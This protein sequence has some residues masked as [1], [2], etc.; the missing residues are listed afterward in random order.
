MDRNKRSEGAVANAKSPVR[1]GHVIT[2]ETSKDAISATAADVVRPA[3]SKQI[4]RKS[5][6]Q[7]MFNTAAVEMFY[8]TP[9]TELNFSIKPKDKIVSSGANPAKEEPGI[10]HSHDEEQ[11]EACKDINRRSSQFPYRSQPCHDFT[12][13]QIMSID[14]SFEMDQRGGVF[15][16]T[17]DTP[18]TLARFTV[19]NVKA[20]IKLVQHCE[21]ISSKGQPSHCRP[22][23]EA[24]NVS[25]MRAKLR[26]FAAQSM[27]YIFNTPRALLASFREGASG[28]SFPTSTVSIDFGCMVQAFHWLQKF[29]EGLQLTMNNLPNAIRSLH[30]TS[31]GRGERRD[32]KP[33]KQCSQDKI[34]V[35]LRAISEDLGNV[36]SQVKDEREAAHLALQVFAVLVAIV[37]PCSLEE[38]HIVYTCHQAQCMEP[39]REVTDPTKIRSAQRILDAFEDEMAL[40]LLSRLCE[41]LATRSWIADM[42]S[43]A[44]TEQREKGIENSDVYR[45]V[46]E[47]VLDKLFESK[48]SPVP[49]RTRNGRLGWKY[50]VPEPDEE[51]SIAPRYI[52]IIAEWLRYLVSKQWDGKADI[53]RFSAVGGALEILWCFGE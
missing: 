26:A 39:P 17:A 28:D 33:S 31:G 15:R 6:A 19:Q 44:R 37:P 23:P 25:Q 7:N 27:F 4:D 47:Y 2:Q 50:D 22:H 30:V 38:W 32:S 10:P 42:E 14:K 35:Q 20:L 13:Y 18:E 16:E 43:I 11:S 3:I 41:A 1:L 51:S 34:P 46:V 5:L 12:T 48:R 40:N 8:N 45:S 21:K 52:G 24:T 9:T 49:Y 53:D 36:N 29:D